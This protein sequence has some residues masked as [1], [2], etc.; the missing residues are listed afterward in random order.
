MAGIASLTQD[1]FHQVFI[2]F[3]LLT[4]WEIGELILLI[5]QKIIDYTIE[6]RHDQTKRQRPPKP[7]N[8]KTRHEMIDQ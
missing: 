8:R 6:N 7:I 1:W 3:R 5:F 4:L 2:Q